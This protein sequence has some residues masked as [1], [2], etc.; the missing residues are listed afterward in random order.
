MRLDPDAVHLVYGD[1]P[2]LGRAEELAAA[3]PDPLFRL[4]PRID[5]SAADD[6]ELRV[7]I[8]EPAVQLFRQEQYAFLSLRPVD[9]GGDSLVG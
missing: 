1:I 6:H 3:L 5:I 9:A 2:Y 4:F 8:E 7:V